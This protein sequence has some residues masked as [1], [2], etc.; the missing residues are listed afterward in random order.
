MALKKE[1]YPIMVL[2]DSNMSC[3]DDLFLRE[4]QKSAG[5]PCLAGEMCEVKRPA[6]LEILEYDGEL[7][8]RSVSRRD[9]SPKEAERYDSKKP[10]DADIL[11]GDGSFRAE[12]HSRVEFTAKKGD[13]FE[14]VRP[15]SSDIWKSEQK[16]DE[17]VIELKMK[18]SSATCAEKLKAVDSERFV[19]DIAERSGACKENWRTTYTETFYEG[20]P[21]EDVRRVLQHENEKFK[22]PG[23]CIEDQSICRTTFKMP[24]TSAKQIQMTSTELK[25]SIFWEDDQMKVES[26]YNIDF[27]PKLKPCPADELIKSIA[28]NHSSTEHFEF[29]R[30]LGGH[31]FYEPKADNVQ[32]DGLD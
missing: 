17:S 10:C 7:E 30:I 25:E 14:A 32:K 5:Y 22:L 23:G 19:Y 24:T 2:I 4:A 26:Q 20:I 12:T 18:R 9:F 8:M 29:Y 21:A 27:V 15:S 11:F 16:Q 1:Y 3:G 31:H 6:W 13:K 28:R